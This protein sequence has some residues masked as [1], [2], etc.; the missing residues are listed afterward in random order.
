MNKK[1]INCF[2]CKHY[3]VTWDPNS[4]RGCKKFG[5]KAKDMPAVLVRISSGMECMYFDEKPNKN[6]EKSIDLNDDD[7]W[8]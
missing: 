5:F 1:K 7:L 6:G 3:Y 2:H 4:P 8:K